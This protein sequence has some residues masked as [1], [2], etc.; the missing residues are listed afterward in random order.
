[1]TFGP[2]TPLYLQPA[3]TTPEAIKARLIQNATALG[4]LDTSTG[5]FEDDVLSAYAIELANAAF[6]PQRLYARVFTRTATG[7]DLDAA[8]DQTGIS[9]R[10]P[11]VQAS[12]IIQ[13]NAPAGTVIP[14]LTRV[15]TGTNPA[16][17]ATTDSVV[18][19]A[20]GATNV[21]VSA[22]DTVGGTAG[23]M[24][25]GA[26]TRLIDAVPGVTSITNTTTFS[27]GTN[28]EQDDA[29]RA[30]VEQ[31]RQEP[32]ASA[33]RAETR[34]AALAVPGVGGVE[35]MYAYTGSPPVAPGDE[36]VSVI[37]AN[38]LPASASLVETVRDALSEPVRITS[39]AELMTLTNGAVVDAGQSGASGTSVHMP[40]GTADN[41]VQG[42][43]D[44]V[45]PQGGPYELL[46]RLKRGATL[47][48]GSVVQVGVWDATAS[49]WATQSALS[50]A[51]AVYQ[52]PAS[53]LPLAFD[54]VYAGDFF[55]NLLD[56]L[57]LRAQRVTAAMVNPTIAPALTAVTDPMSTLLSGTYTVGYAW[58]VNGTTLLSPTAA[59]TIVAGQRID[60]V[61]PAAPLGVQSRDVYVSPAAGNAAVI[62][63]GNASNPSGVYT[64]LA[65][66]VAGGATAPGANTTLDT[67]T[68]VW[69][70]NMFYRSAMQRADMDQ[71][72]PGF[73]RLRVQ[74][75]INVPV[76]VHVT[77]TYVAGLD[78]AA[79]RAAIRAALSG[80]PTATSLGGYFTTI[81]FGKGVNQVV[82]VGAIGDVIFRTSG[83]ASYDFAT[84][85]V[86]GAQQNITVL[87][88][89][90]ATLRDLIVN[91]VAV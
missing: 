41:L 63:H 14:A 55:A 75:A 21:G 31:A 84:L 30:R 46:P 67:T 58:H 78:P 89:Q 15:A 91:G 82:Q 3:Q 24:P 37:D 29:L 79:V 32:G 26:Y 62:Y 28:A 90:R 34:T 80:A 13:F 65:L 8:A 54:N 74:S 72:L 40:S 39:E 12:G 66:P 77:L 48:T 36:R 19:V 53:A 83:V 85:T 10:L 1:M 59:I 11:A 47:G 61:P 25:I 68:D 49:S 51:F 17:T 35:I 22:H 42:R 71:T 86:N 64:I 7:A 16:R 5:S 76:D 44:L 18:T 57:E 6:L 81:P 33:N 50:N 38:G 2:Q 70:D 45:L 23:N 56:Q 20:V 88:E 52:L 73:F 9:G 43:I 69:L 60:S 87:P 27:G 4:A